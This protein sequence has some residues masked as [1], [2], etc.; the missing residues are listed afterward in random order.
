VAIDDSPRTG[1]PHASDRRR[2]AWLTRTL[3][4]IGPR[5][6]RDI[7]AA[8]DETKALYLPLLQAAPRAGIGI[9]RDLAYGAHPRQVLD[10]YRPAG[11][12]AA[13]VLAFV[14]GGAFVRG[15]KDTNAQMYGNVLTWFARQG[16]IG[17]NIEYRLAGDAPYPGGALDVAAACAW[18]ETHIAEHGGDPARVCLLGHSAGGTHAATYACDPALDA[19][20]RPLAGLVLVSAR[21]RADVSPANPNAAGVRAYF[22]SAYERVSPVTH[23]ARMTVPTFIV[24]A[25]FENPLLDLYGLEFALALARARGHAPL[26]VTMADHNHVSIM[27]HFNTPEQLLGEMILDFFEHACG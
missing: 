9:T 6:A 22:G 26:H 13:P 16:W 2:A 17:V 12:R 8:G 23:A 19:V 1:V 10:I 18:M 3:R 7:G 4:E 11:A 20:R 5:W 14:H 25:E 21:V 27:A 15:S 24:N